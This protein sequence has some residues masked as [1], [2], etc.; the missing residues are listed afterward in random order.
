MFESNQARGELEAMLVESRPCSSATSLLEHESEVVGLKEEITQL[1]SAVRELETDK[2]GTGNG[3]SGRQKRL[4]SFNAKVRV[5]EQ[6]K[7][8]A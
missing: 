5:D 1:K 6:V 3:G 8:R 4:Q 2:N 7:L